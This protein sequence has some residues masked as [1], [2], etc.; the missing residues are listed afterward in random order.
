MDPPPWGSTKI[1]WMTIDRRYKRSNT[2]DDLMVDPDEYSYAANL[3]LDGSAMWRVK[4]LY[5][6]T[7]C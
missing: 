6:L 5:I 2:G 4:C 3:Y 7:A 1:F